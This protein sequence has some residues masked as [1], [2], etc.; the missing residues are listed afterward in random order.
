MS[1]IQKKSNG[2]TIVESLVILVI[3]LAIS[4]ASYYV[5]R[6]SNNNKTTS[7]STASTST[8]SSA[9]PSSA[10]VAA[11]TSRQNDASAVMAGVDQ[12]INNNLVS[13]SKVSAGSSKVLD[14][15]GSDCSSSSTVTVNLNYFAASAVSMHSYSSSL[16][17]TNPQK[18]YI[19]QNASCNTALDNLISPNS[20]RK[21]NLA[22]LYALQEGS[23][24]A[25]KCYPS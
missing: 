9:T 14:I 17:N 1:K 2:F 24:V 5:G 16:T 4:L 10:Q 22:V 23:G 21:F 3:L 19:V 20:G 13:P 8:S 15:C 11:N 12:Y 7:A 6:H 18:V 25:Q